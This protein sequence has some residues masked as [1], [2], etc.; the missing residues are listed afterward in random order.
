MSP[1]DR[2]AARH[3]RGWLTYA[4][5]CEVFAV[6]GISVF[7]PLCLEQ[8]ARDN[9]FLYPG[10]T[11][12]CVDAKALAGTDEPEKRCV[13]KIGWAQN[14]HL[15]LYV[16]SLSV[17]LQALTVISMGG[18]ADH[19][20][21]RKP[22]LLT[23]AYLGSISA[24]LFS[25][26]P[27]SS[28]LWPLVGL[29]ACG[30]NVGFGAS[31]V[32]LN[33]YLPNL[34]RETKEV[35]EAYQELLAFRSQH[36]D[37]GPPNVIP[38]AGETPEQ[39]YNSALARAT[40]KI[41]S[42]GIAMGYVAGILL[43]ICTTIPVAAL[44]SSTL[45]L[46]LA[47]GGTGLWWALGSIP[48]GIWLPNGSSL[49]LV[50][51]ADLVVEQVDK[52]PWSWS[53]EILNAWKRLGVMLRWSE[54]KRLKNTFWYLSAWFLL[55][56][57]FAT[58]SSTAVLFGKTTLNMPSS[59]LILVGALAPIGGVLGSLTWPLVQRKIGWTD[60]QMIKLFV[61][62]VSLIPL[63]GTLGV[64]DIFKSHK[65]P[66]G[67]LT[68]PG[69]MYGLAFVYGPLLVGLIA[70]ATGS[71]RNGFYFLT[72]IMWIS[73]PL[74]AQVNVLRGADDAKAYIE[75]RVSHSALVNG[76]YTLLS[77]TDSE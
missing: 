33:S 5:A 53:R 46:R 6:V 2:T 57:G 52:R 77:Q 36:L 13:V 75:E 62:L 71:I 59:K 28:I 61:S 76:Q 49:K 26:I 3:I 48:A 73:L 8:F 68:T 1:E 54:I 25:V 66:F 64:L 55:S 44:H 24:I 67:G 42:L 16:F 19:P 23:F 40:A 60:L 15:S 17:A 12:R 11:E 74:L 20:P 39:F 51:G 35:R 47:I 18:I 32:A 38:N 9:G 65:L 10:K 63:Y 69:E 21:H 56:D 31:F 58:I 45:S 29:L 7:L 41:S 43:L 50:E 37:Q 27:S 30:A 14:I 22:L 72:A 34:A 70:D 4:F